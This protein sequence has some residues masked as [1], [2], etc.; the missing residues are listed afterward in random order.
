VCAILRPHLPLALLVSRKFH[1]ILS[2]ACGRP[3]KYL[4]VSSARI[5]QSLQGVNGVLETLENQMMAFVSRLLR[6][7]SCRRAV[8]HAEIMNM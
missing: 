7:A 1:L 5:S 3:I 4:S 6:S 8:E 2:M